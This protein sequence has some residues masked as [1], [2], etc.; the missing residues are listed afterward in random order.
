MSFGQKLPILSLNEMYS[1]IMTMKMNFWND[2]L[3]KISNKKWFISILKWLSFGR[4]LPI[5]SSNQI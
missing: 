4:K 3:I 5:L 2:F 1:D